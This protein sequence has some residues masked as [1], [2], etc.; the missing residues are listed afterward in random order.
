MASRI[1][2]RPRERERIEEELR[3]EP[4]LSDRDYEKLYGMR[5]WLR[6]RLRWGP[7]VGGIVLAFATQLVLTALALW[8]GLLTTVPTATGG[9]PT[10]LAT[11]IGIG[12]AISALVSLFVGGYFAARVAGVAG[13]LDG[14]LNGLI[15]WA[16]VLFLGA[17]LSSFT[18]LLGVGS[19]L[20]F[21]LGGATGAGD[22][23]SALGLTSLPNIPPDQVAAIQSFA[24][25][26]AGWFLLGSILS[27]IAAVAGGYVG[28]RK[29]TV[30]VQQ[31]RP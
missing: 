19:L 12:T 22:V 16:T 11:S 6:D 14:A 15:V 30:H 9:L 10:G 28:A 31:P 27:L 29:R 17:V 26:A 24:T 7:V 25:N 18:S 2:E 13:R 3:L 5:A 23:L 20:G 8:I 1:E 21:R 4:M